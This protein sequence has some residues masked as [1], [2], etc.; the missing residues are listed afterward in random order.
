VAK[1]VE[2]VK[3]V[4]SAARFTLAAVLWLHSL[5]LIP[6]HH[7]RISSIANYFHASALEFSLL[8]LLLLF[9]IASGKG[10]WR[11][12]GNV[13]YIYFFPFV[14][15]SLILW[16]LAR[17]LAWLA[18][19]MSPSA[20]AS[21]NESLLSYLAKSDGTSETATSPEEKR[22]ATGVF[23]E[24][25][26]R[27]LRRFRVV[28]CILL[29]SASHR[30]IVYIALPIV[31]YHLMR[32]VWFLISAAFF[33]GR[34]PSIGQGLA[35]MAE[36]MITKLR[37]VT[38]ASDSTEELRNLW[39]QISGFELGISILRNQSWVQQWAL[40]LMSVL[41]GVVYLTFPFFS[42]SCITVSAM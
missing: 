32:A 28:W 40:L 1:E 34:L 11:S 17:M 39:G 18:R 4:R 5:F 20:A 33:S 35:N 26:T 6:A 37:D 10:F 13:A 8:L 25:M 9:S 38:R 15:I 31:A 12:V 29:V 42:H 41:A 36:G 19:Q 14:L 24:I 22:P 30:A 21:S 27:P 23:R 2:V 7:E 16:K 3:T